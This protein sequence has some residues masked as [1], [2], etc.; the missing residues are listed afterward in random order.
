MLVLFIMEEGFIFDIWVYIL[1]KC[2]IFVFLKKNMILLFFMVLYLILVW[3]VRFVI[4]LMGVLIFLIVRN[5][6][7]FV[8]Y[9]EIKMRVKNY[10][11][12][13]KIWF[14]SVDGDE[15]VLFCKRDLNMN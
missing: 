8:V 7:K 1:V 4:D 3:D 6:V 9:D 12:L 10:Y 13:V 5:V 11:V 2:L 14:G 15:F